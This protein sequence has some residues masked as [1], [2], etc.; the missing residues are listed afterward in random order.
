MEEMNKDLEYYTLTDENG[1]ETDYELIGTCEMKGNTYYA[2]V[3]AEADE[4]AENTP[5]QEKTSKKT[6]TAPTKEAATKKPKE[7]DMRLFLAELFQS[8]EMSEEK[9]VK[10]A[11]K[12]SAYIKC[13]D[14]LKSG[15]REFAKAEKALKKEIE[16]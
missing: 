3:P 2:L 4:N 5:N 9:I 15:N 8:G 7:K 1:V 13:L 14:E 6:E 11:D 16:K 10:A 12:L